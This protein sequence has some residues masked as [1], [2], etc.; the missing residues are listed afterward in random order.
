[1]NL[2]LTRFI[3]GY[4]KDFDRAL[5]EVQNGEKQTHWMWYIFPQIKG[6]GR[7]DTARFFSIQDLDEAR[8]FL[9]DPYLGSNFRKICEVL[10][11]QDTNNPQKIFGYIDS[12]KLHSSMTLFSEVDD[13][14]I[15]LKVL[16]KYFRGEKDDQ[17]LSIIKM[18][19]LN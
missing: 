12:M 1:M 17:T 16:D 19:G 5:E 14:Q 7:S 6:L 9:N 18:N 10:L 8:A 3:E 11:E 15:F 4:E 2:D 13:D